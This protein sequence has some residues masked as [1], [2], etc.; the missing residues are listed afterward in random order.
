ITYHNH[1]NSCNRQFF[2]HTK[3]TPPETDSAV[4]HSIVLSTS[5]PDSIGRLSMHSS[6]SST[7]VVFKSRT[8]TPTFPSR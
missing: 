7:P 6:R 2:G 5:L 1:C 8:P 4:A 3:T